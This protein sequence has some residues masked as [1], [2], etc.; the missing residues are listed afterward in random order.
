MEERLKSII[1]RKKETSDVK[2]KFSLPDG[3][4]SVEFK[5]KENWEIK[6]KQINDVKVPKLH[7][8]L[9]RTPNQRPPS[10]FSEIPLP[11]V[12]S[13]IILSNTI[14]Q[15]VSRNLSLDASPFP[16]SRTLS[17]DRSPVLNKTIGNTMT[18]LER[19]NSINI[20]EMINESKYIVEPIGQSIAMIEDVVSEE[21]LSDSDELN[22]ISE[23]K[24]SNI[25]QRKPQVTINSPRKENL[26]HNNP[27]L[28]VLAKGSA[29][30]AKKESKIVK[31][32]K[33]LPKFL[34]EKMKIPLHKLGKTSNIGSPPS[35]PRSSDSDIT[36]S[37][38]D[39]K[40]LNAASLHNLRKIN[41]AGPLPKIISVAITALD[42]KGRQVPLPEDIASKLP[43]AIN[44]VIPRD[45]PV[46]VQ[47]GGKGGPIKEVS[48]DLTNSEGKK[49]KLRIKQCSIM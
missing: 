25:I 45:I 22:E 44:S 4:S 13:Q 30:R 23:I 6:I 48:V 18:P 46:A 8:P 36:I 33:K 1:N 2:E 24:L 3:V 26:P 17:V 39:I 35:S 32:T 21:T 49:E 19:K 15:P 29:Q 37:A 47:Q 42:D 7:K 43:F 34:R 28:I 16:L 27:N 12:T 31:A 38:V 11:I 41:R 5:V 10:V 14:Q 20:L 40:K 9:P